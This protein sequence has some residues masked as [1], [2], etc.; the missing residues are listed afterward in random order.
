MTATATDKRKET[1]QIDLYLTALEAS[2]VQLARGRR[3]RDWLEN[4]LKELDAKIPATTGVQKLLLIQDHEETRNDLEAF[5]QA[6][7][8]AELEKGFIKHAASYSERHGISFAAWRR[9]GVSADVLT[10]AGV[11]R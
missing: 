6:D 4:H 11:T 10:E 5:K 1:K 3:T 9:V 2:R 7:N 8:M